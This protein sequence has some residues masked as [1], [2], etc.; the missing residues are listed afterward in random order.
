MSRLTLILRPLREVEAQN[1]PKT[2]CP[3]FPS[4]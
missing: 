4:F 1:E 2:N 3:D